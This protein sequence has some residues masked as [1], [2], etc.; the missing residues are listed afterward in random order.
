MAKINGIQINTNDL[1]AEGG[2]R[3]YTITGTVGAQ[4]MLQVVTSEGL[5]YNFENKTFIAEA[6]SS[7][8]INSITIGVGG[9][10]SGL[11]S[12]PSGATTTYSVIM[13]TGGFDTTIGN[14]TRKSS[15]TKIVQN[16]NV[17]LTLAVATATA[18]RYS[19]DPAS[20]NI[21]SV[22]AKATASSVVVN[23]VYTIVNASSDAQ[24]FGFSNP[25]IGSSFSGEDLW[26]FET[27]ETVDGAV[28]SSS[29]LAVVDDLTD[30]VV[31]MEL[32]YITG[33]TAPGAATTITAIDINSRTLTLS[34]N[35]ALSD[36][37]TMT[38]RAY[39]SA[40]INNAIGCGLSI[41]TINYEQGDS[42]ITTVRTDPGGSV[43]IPVNGTYG[44]GTNSVTGVFVKAPGIRRDNS[45]DKVFSVNSVSSSAGEITVGDNDAG[46]TGD[47]QTL[48]VGLPVTFSSH[49]KAKLNTT[50]TVTSY[51]GANRTI[52]LDL[53]KIVN[54]N[55]AT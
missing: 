44:I 8:H 7:E 17:T 47:Q 41:G 45:G 19:S 14:S 43:V 51:P 46:T 52:N 50:I 16:S 29:N 33:T 28:S 38:F 20:S 12:F 27:T 30:L 4:L 49:V 35:Q 42:V 22:G 37:A 1:P 23:P 25:T 24:G 11:I 2:Q 31:G 18:A 34:R 48:P 21:T 53:D 26:Y 40:L 9:T 3:Y 36:G 32:T 10:Y 55:T 15:I 5:L 13:L 54:H 39:G 6:S